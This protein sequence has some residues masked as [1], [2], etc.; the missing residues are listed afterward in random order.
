MNINVN[1][2]EQ[3]QA[4][5]FIDNDLDGAV[6]PFFVFF[7]GELQNNGGDP[8]TVLQTTGSIIDDIVFTPTATE[9]QPLVIVEVG[10][11]PTYETANKFAVEIEATTAIH[12]ISI[13]RGL[14][15]TSIGNH[16]KYDNVPIQTIISAEVTSYEQDKIVTTFTVDTPELT[17]GD[18]IAVNA[19]LNNKKIEL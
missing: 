15:G 8:T 12:T 7:N 3:V 6:G 14:F 2:T 18:E 9:F 4:F 10:D 19:S 13:Q 5:N 17:P 16:T 11:G 1:I